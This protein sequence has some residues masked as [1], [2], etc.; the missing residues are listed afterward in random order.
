MYVHPSDERVVLAAMLN[1]NFNN[2]LDEPFVSE[3]VRQEQFVQHNLNMW[4]H[5]IVAPAPE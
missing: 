1:F 5:C 2:L 4:V 3:V